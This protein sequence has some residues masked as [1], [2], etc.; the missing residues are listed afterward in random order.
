MRTQT[1]YR[2]YGQ[3]QLEGIHASAEIDRPMHRRPIADEV[4]PMTV[5][6]PGGFIHR[7]T[8][9]GRDADGLV[10]SKRV[11]LKVDQLMSRRHA[12]ATALAKISDSLDRY[13]ITPLTGF[14]T[15]AFELV[16]E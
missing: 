2:L 8:V 11:S 13:G 1:W 3:A 6:R 15:G 12:I 10:I 5:R 14:H 4:Q 9:M 7:V 16:G